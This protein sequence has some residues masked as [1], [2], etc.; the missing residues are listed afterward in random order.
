M[1]YLHNNL[2]ETA[3]HYLP[4]SEEDLDAMLKTVGAEDLSTLFDYIPSDVKMIGDLNVPE[5]L[6][7]DDAREYFKQLAAK[8][9]HVTSFIGDGLPDFQQHEIADYVLGIRNLT[10]AYTPYQPERS[11]GTLITLWI[12]QC[13]M[14]KLTGFE[15]INSS[16]YDRASALFEAICCATRVRRKADIALIS[17]AIYPGDREVIN[18][19]IAETPLTVK[20]IASDPDTGRTSLASLDQLLEEFGNRVATVAFPQTNNLGLLEDV[21]ALTDRAN[22]AGALVTAIIDP[23]L[24]ATG[25]LKPPAEFGSDGADIIVG[26]GQHLAI[27]PNFGGPGLGV[28]GVRHNEKTNNLVRATPGRYVGKAKDTDGR[29]CFVIVLATREQHIRKDKATSNICS[30]QAYIATVAGAAMLAKGES[31]M[32]ESIRIAR[33]NALNFLK[34]SG[35]QL[36]FPHTPFFNEVCVAVDNAADILKKAQQAGILAGVDASTR[37]PGNRQLIKLAFSDKHTVKDIQQLAAI[38]TSK[39]HAPDAASLPDNLQRNGTVN[40]PQHSIEDVKAF[41]RPPR[42]TQRQPR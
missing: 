8:N 10:T 6:S 37:L 19:L 41:L 35:A 21:D 16:L 39:K 14:A 1:S 23:I 12:Y 17:E 42:H 36:A 26:E 38:F 33:E 9:K 2:R 27:G 20:W 30:N 18:T 11:Q 31:G 4:A 13:M 5:E 22:A 24:L 29:D 15:A 25:G 40:L 3:R 7:Y 28:F 34:L 32:A